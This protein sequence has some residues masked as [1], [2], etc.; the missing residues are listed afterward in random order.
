MK[1][2]INFNKK[3]TSSK[4]SKLTVLDTLLR[5]AKEDNLV[6]QNIINQKG[7]IVA[8]IRVRGK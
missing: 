2:K 6:S 5:E 8:K 7:D 3:F 4:K 1:I